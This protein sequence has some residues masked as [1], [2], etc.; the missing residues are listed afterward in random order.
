MTG[1]TLAANA[2]AASLRT[3]MEAFRAAARRGPPS[4]TPRCLAACSAALVRVSARARRQRFQI[5]GSSAYGTPP[6]GE[7][8]GWQKIDSG[9]R[10]LQSVG[11]ATPDDA[12]V[13]LAR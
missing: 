5:F 4:L 12:S 10:L 1:R 13:E 11:F 3:F 8:V 9:R 7:G 2:S 6:A